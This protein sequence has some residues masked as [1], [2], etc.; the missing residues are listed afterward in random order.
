MKNTPFSRA[1]PSS[2]GWRAPL[3]ALILAMGAPAFSALTDLATA[4]LETSTSTLVKP[5]IMYILDDSGSMARDNLPDWVC[6]TA[7]LPSITNTSTSYTSGCVYNANV[8]PWL[9]R[10]SKFN[11]IYYDPS[12]TYTPPV[13]Y[14]GTSYTSYN[15]ATLWTKVPV[16]GFGIISTSTIDLTSSTTWPAT[17]YTFIPGE[18]CTSANLRTCNTQSAAT[19]AY[20]YPAYLRWCTSSALSDCQARYIYP[21]AITVNGSSV[22]YNYPRYPGMSSTATIAL[23]GS[24]STSVSGITVNGVQIMSA[25]ASAS[26]TPATLAASIVTAINNCTSSATGNCTASGYSA[27]RSSA[28]ITITSPAGAGAITYTPVVTKSGNMTATV[29]AFSGGTPGTWVQT[30]ISSSTTS[31]PYPG[32][33]A[34]ATTRT[35][36]AS[37]SGCTY[38]EEMTN[39]ANWYAYYHT[40][41]QATKTA[42]S[43]AFQSLSTNYRLGYMSLNNN[44]GSDFLNIADITTASGGQKYLWYNKVFATK[45]ANSTPLKAAL[46]KAGQYYAGKY[47]S[48]SSGASTKI[49][50]KINSVTATDPVQ[51]ACQRNYTMLFTDGYWNEDTT[52]TQVDGSTA[53]GDVDGTSSG[54]SRPY[55]DGSSNANTLADVAEY[56]YTTDLRSSALGTATNASGTDV[57]SNSYANGKQNMV[58]STIGLGASGYMLFNADYASATSGD[59][60]D[61]YNGT[62]AS[63]ANQTSGVCIWQSSGSCTWP[64]PAKNTQT[65][66]DDLWHAAINGRGSYYSATNAAEIKT[67]LTNFLSSVDATTAS[68]AAVAQSTPVLTT[69]SDAYTFATRYCSGKWFGD[70]IR[71]AVDASTGATSTTPDWSESGAGTDCESTSGSLTT[72]ALLDK[73]TYTDRTIFTYDASSK[74]KVSFDWDSG[75][76]TTMKS[77]FKIAAISGLSQL[78]TSGTSCLA[79]TSQVDSSTAGTTTGAGGI[80]LVNYL[81][82]DRQNEGSTNTSYYRART[83]VLGDVV[84]STPVYVQTPSFSYTDTGYAAFKTANASRQGMVYVG[85]ND[86]MLHAFNASTGAEVWA[87]IPSM[88]LPN[89]YKLADKNYASN[90]AFFVDGQITKA[91]VY[92]D[93]AWHTILVG[94]LGGGGRG[95]FALDVTTPS[96]PKV[97]WEFSNSSTT[98]PSLYDVNLGYTYGAPVVTKLSDGTWAVIVSSGYNNVS[99]GDGKGRLWVLNAQTGAKLHT[100]SN[101]MGTTSS[102]GVVTGCTT[103]PCPSGLAQITGWVDSNTNN[104]ATQIYGGDLFGN[105]WRF[106]I[107]SLTASGGTA[108]V[109]LLATLY[110]ASSNRQPIT[111]TPELGLVSKRRFVFVGTGA[112]L[113]VTDVTTTQQQTMYAI[114]DPLT[115]TS[116]TTALFTNPRASTCASSTATGCFAQV[117]WTDT[118]NVRYSTATNGITA[119]LSTMDGWYADLPETGE[120][121]NVDPVLY[122]GELYFVSNSPSTSGACSTGGSSY[123]NYVNYATG[124][125]TT[126]DG[127]TGTLLSST[128]MASAAVLSINS[129]GQVVWT[130][131]VN[132]TPTSGV[133]S[134]SSSGTA[135]RVTWRRLKNA[136]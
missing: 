115:G 46:T 111:T 117:T 14:A 119:S 19:T 80:N 48:S 70:L 128:G 96:S 69:G 78:C 36:C 105:L 109:Q 83:H 64:T 101:G 53:I 31:Y 29:T 114:R 82:G 20:P 100:L 81:R 120:R 43:L 13:N 85:S 52:P 4:P 1:W 55:L 49:S 129:S 22:L 58:T 67:G 98:T 86:G 27:T 25:T 92:Y 127:S 60:Y 28:T 23:S 57:S 39:F 42:T 108:T 2:R 63:T 16:D 54:E 17:Y 24:S 44:T 131:N 112:Y 65:G 89:L 99:D 61:V 118:S 116:T 75:L 35:D 15:T 124:L 71:Y 87:Y 132:G 68:S 103:A 79:S 77:Y 11:G 9:A 5:N 106:D 40:R 107:S 59:Y 130:T 41:M 126:S 102:G 50:T 88:V 12:V 3:C 123:I 45:A 91:D 37:T 8:T 34:V 74:A 72:T 104:K 51:Y 94:G 135:R 90:H 97:L 47:S 121:V 56:Y 18:Y 84:N 113:G 122:S 76:T 62:T 38:A 32:T 66:I 30:T 110:D 73:T 26:S 33:S 133:R 93:S 7:S 95:Y 136:Q 6:G 21:T 125:S 10:N 134:G